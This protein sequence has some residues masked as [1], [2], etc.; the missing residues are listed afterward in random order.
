MAIADDGIWKGDTG[1]G[2]LEDRLQKNRGN[3]T[4]LKTIHAPSWVGSPE[5]RGTTTILWSCII[6][7]VA[8][9]YTAL[10]LNVPGNR[11]AM[12]MLRE[13]LKWVLIGLIA[14]EVVLYL[15]SSQFLDARRLSKELTLLWRQQKSG[16]Q[17]DMQVE[18]E[19]GLK[20]TEN[21]PC[22]DIKYGFFVI[23]GGLEV[24]VTDIEHFT[25]RWA[26]RGSLQSGSLR[27][28][29]NGVLQLAKLG[30][31]IPIPR[32]KIDDK[33]KADTL[34]KFLVMT[35]VIWM[36]L[37]CIVRKA[38]GLPVSLLEIHTMVHVLCAVVMFIF[39]FKKPK[40]MMDPEVVDTGEFH[41]IISLMVQEQFH[42]SKSEEM[43]FYPK[44]SGGGQ[45]ESSQEPAF[46]WIHPTDPNQRKYL[47]DQDDRIKP[48]EWVRDD[49]PRLM[50]KT[51]E[52]LPSGL[53]VV[54]RAA[55]WEIER[56]QRRVLPDWFDDR[57]YESHYDIPS[58]IW[59]TEWV[60]SEPVPPT[61]DLYAAD[62]VRWKYVIAAVEYLEGRIRQP[63]LFHEHYQE[64][65]YPDSNFHDAFT[66]S[67][68]NFQ[69]TGDSHVDPDQIVRFIFGSPILLILL[70]LLP[71]LYGGIHL[72]VAGT[73]F[74]TEIEQLLW[75]IASYDIITTMP[76]FFL[77]TAIGSGIS[78]KFFEYESIAE[79]SWAMFYKFP[80]HVM[81]LAYGLSRSFLVVESFISL[82]DVPI[83][84][85][86]TPSWLQTI[87]HV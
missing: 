19:D 62:I 85:Y 55:A 13:K 25:A 44:T 17:G 64:V 77:L 65:R 83:G 59:I 58:S 80:G 6:T 10:H 39:W 42:A 76:A 53:S 26:T 78:R 15:A 70:L 16:E 57:Q 79:D 31:F 46:V 40:D 63:E 47:R 12:A 18:D 11:K 86:W 66:R 21:D 34:Q 45:Y 72:M 35:Q 5:I 33:S 51:G 23:M 32:S 43:V 20:D 75:T 67:A 36:A 28:S 68:G 87:P 27:L 4:A 82:R 9:I 69:Y 52:A 60:E 7:L 14:P 74:P 8:C 56:F 71:G 41:H 54:A 38:Y 30:H 29:V 73:R 2:V 24:D 22:F 37:Q 1:L 84:T 49:G 48:V 81:F 50:L 61:V 3:L